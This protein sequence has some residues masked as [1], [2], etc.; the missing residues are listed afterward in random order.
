MA[1]GTSDLIFKSVKVTIQLPQAGRQ[2]VLHGRGFLEPSCSKCDDIS[3]GILCT[4]S[5][6]IFEER[7]SFDIRNAVIIHHIDSWTGPLPCQSLS[8]LGL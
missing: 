7:H 6:S 2:I 5:V 4:G 1:I 3:F 8:R